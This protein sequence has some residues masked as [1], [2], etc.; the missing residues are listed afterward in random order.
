MVYTDFL[1]RE[2][3]YIALATGGAFLMNMYSFAVSFWLKFSFMN[4]VK[5]TNL[6]KYEY[7]YC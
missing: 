2:H 1:M 6:L 3:G 7:I 5:V 4:G